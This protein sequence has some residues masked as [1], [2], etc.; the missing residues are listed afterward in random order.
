MIAQGCGSVIFFEARKKKDLYL[1]MSKAPDGPSV[2]FLANNGENGTTFV[3]IQVPTWY[4]IHTDSF[5]CGQQAK[6]PFQWQLVQDVSMTSWL[7]PRSAHHG[8]AEAERKS[9]EGLAACVEL[10]CGGS[11]RF[12]PYLSFHALGKDNC[13]VSILTTAMDKLCTGLLQAFDEQPHLQLLKEMLT[14][15]FGTPKKHPKSKPFLDHVL[16][17]SVAEG[18][19]WLRNYQV[20]F[21][22]SL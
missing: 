22:P 14:Q 3:H 18:R 19:V 9:S 8:R 7:L 21:M 15:I 11:C 13:S 1:W 2:K 10:P 12:H 16:N 17:F 4:I 20:S 6:P 5:H